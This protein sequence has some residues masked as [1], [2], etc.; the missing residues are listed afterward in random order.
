MRK[1][2]PAILEKARIKS[3]ALKSNASYGFNGAFFMEPLTIIS[4]DQMGWDHVSVSTPFRCPTFE[5]LKMIKDLF[6]SEEETVFHFFPKKSEYISFHPYCLHLWKKHGRDYE[7]P[8][9]E[10]IF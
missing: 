4:A 10:M 5:E 8:P 3:T 1:K 2:V 7:L 6:W 9:K